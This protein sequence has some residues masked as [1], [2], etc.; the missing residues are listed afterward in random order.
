MANKSTDEQA[1]SVLEKRYLKHKRRRLNKKLK[2][3]S[4][5]LSLSDA[6]V[7]VYNVNEK[8]TSDGHH[9]IGDVFGAEN[10]T[11]SNDPSSLTSNRMIGTTTKKVQRQQRLLEK[12]ANLGSSPIN[13]IQAIAAKAL[14]FK[15]KN[16]RAALKFQS[17]QQQIQIND[18]EASGSSSSSL[19]SLTNANK[20]FLNYLLSVLDKYIFLSF[21]SHTF[22]IFDY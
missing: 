12:V 2:Q 14:N 18:D 6:E 8:K 16:S 13:V 4:E 11:N 9:K 20:V 7:D 10:N 17:Q 21:V 22:N 5:R 19:S 3:L 15:L 1:I